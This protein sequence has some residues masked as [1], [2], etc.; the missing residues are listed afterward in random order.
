M[1]V[2]SKY[3]GKHPILEVPFSSYLFHR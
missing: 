1:A 2:G 3:E